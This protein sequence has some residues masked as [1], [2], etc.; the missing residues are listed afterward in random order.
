MP[1]ASSPAISSLTFS[2]D[3]RQMVG[4]RRIACISD[5]C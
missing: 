1:S 5:G 3:I 2:P 4:A